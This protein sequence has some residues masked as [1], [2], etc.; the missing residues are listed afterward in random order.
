MSIKY[1][2]VFKAN[3]NVFRLYLFYF[4]D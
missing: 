4:I 3:Y 2:L 1:V